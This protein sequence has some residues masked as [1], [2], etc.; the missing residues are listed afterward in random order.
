[1]AELKVEL[2]SKI[3][4]TERTCIMNLNGTLYLRY[5]HL[6]PVMDISPE[7]EFIPLRMGNI[8]ISLLLA[9][10]MVSQKI[11]DLKYE[12]SFLIEKGHKFQNFELTFKLDFPIND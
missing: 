2:L 3:L 7:E 4:E 8:F 9:R 11:A 12:K 1:M 6:F 10:K 5:V